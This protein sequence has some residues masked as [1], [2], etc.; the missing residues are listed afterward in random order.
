MTAVMRHNRRE[1]A[2]KLLGLM[3][4]ERLLTFARTIQPATMWALRDLTTAADDA[5]KTFDL[6]REALRAVGGR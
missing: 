3:R 4:R 5:T 1:R 2:E 6:L